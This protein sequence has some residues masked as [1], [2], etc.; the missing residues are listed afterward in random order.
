MRKGILGITAALLAV[1]AMV[2]S[3]T[4]CDGLFQEKDDGIEREVT[5]QNFSNAEITITCEGNP[6]TTVLPRPDLQG[7]K[8]EAKVKRTGFPIK[9]KTIAITNPP[10]VVD[11]WNYIELTGSLAPASKQGKN[12]LSLDSGTLA[13]NAA[14]TGDFNPIGWKIS[15][16]PQDD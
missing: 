8:T 13:F 1:L 2:L 9:L 7:S 6:V 5:F 16:I 15:I 10:N 4:T 12:D 14:R 11:P 3:F